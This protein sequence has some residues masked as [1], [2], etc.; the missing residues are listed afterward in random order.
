ML[1]TVG[2]LSDLPGVAVALDAALIAGARPLHHHHDHD[3]DYHYYCCSSNIS[4]EFELAR[5]LVIVCCQQK[6]K[7]TTHFLR[8]AGA[9][10][11]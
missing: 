6:Q 11:L 9:A 8:S 1:D 4:R 2:V 3:H 10:R 5:R 7:A